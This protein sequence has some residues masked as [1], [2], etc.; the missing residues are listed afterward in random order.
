MAIDAVVRAV[1]RNRDG[2]ATMTLGPR[3]TGHG[4]SCKGQAKMTILNPPAGPLRGLVG[5]EIWGGD[6]AIMVGDRKWAVRV[7]YTKCRLVRTK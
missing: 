5:V 2:T 1:R 7:G 6:G 4:S 3:D